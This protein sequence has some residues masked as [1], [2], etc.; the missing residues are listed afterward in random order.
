M[1]RHNPPYL[2]RY[3]AVLGRR[4]GAGL[5]LLLG[6]E[7]AALGDDEGLHLDAD[8]GEDL[9]RHLVAADALDRLVELD[10]A[11]VDPHLARPPDLVRDVRGRD[12]AEE[13]P[14][15]PRLDLEAEHRLAQELADLAALLERPRLVARPL[16][17]AP[18]ELLDARRGRDLRQPPWQQVV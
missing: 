14:G 16:R 12:G 17:V 5:G 11:P 4:L 13:R 6:R 8:V 10:L 15:R 7:L 3:R 18:P 1:V 9:D 2:L